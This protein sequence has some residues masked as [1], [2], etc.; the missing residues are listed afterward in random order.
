MDYLG[1]ASRGSLYICL[2]AAHPPGGSSGED[3]VGEG[4]GGAGGGA[5]RP[6]LQRTLPGEQQQV[7]GDAEGP[8]LYL[9]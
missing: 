2:A 4:G 3:G 6:A 7:R 5:G 9:G 8:C 1:F